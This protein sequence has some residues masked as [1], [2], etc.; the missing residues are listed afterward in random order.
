[1]ESL[2]EIAASVDLNPPFSI[3]N[4]F[5]PK[6]EAKV[7]EA[8]GRKGMSENTRENIKRSLKVLSKSSNVLNWIKLLFFADDIAKDCPPPPQYKPNPDATHSMDKLM[9]VM[10]RRNNTSDANE[11]RQLDHE[12][13][14]RMERIE[15]EVN[16]A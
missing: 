8:C 13:I 10:E 15:K 11:K 9:G 16:I 5:N 7:D 6:I 4:D 3:K 12:I 14:E 2:K 1:L